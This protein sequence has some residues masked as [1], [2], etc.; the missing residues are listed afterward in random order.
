VRAHAKTIVVLVVITVLGFLGVRKLLGGV[1]PAPSPV[2]VGSA[3]ARVGYRP[4]TAS[5][6]P[7]VVTVDAVYAYCPGTAAC[8]GEGGDVD[9]PTVGL[10][11][12]YLVVLWAPPTF[13][14]SL[15]RLSPPVTGTGWQEYARLVLTAAP[16]S[17]S[18]DPRRQGWRCATR[19]GPVAT[20]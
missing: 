2:D 11:G 14:L 10:T 17:A 5:W 4:V 12:P 13:C 1:T 8:D 9:H 16:T 15:L 19:P 6:A 7:A 20:R 18:S 3:M